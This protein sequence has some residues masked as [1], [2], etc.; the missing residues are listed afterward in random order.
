MDI[1]LP[2]PTYEVIAVKCNFINGSGNEKYNNKYAYHIYRDNDHPFFE[3]GYLFDSIDEA[4]NHYIKFHLIDSSDWR[5]EKNKERMFIYY[6]P[7]I[8][9]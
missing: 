2:T 6:K 1:K 7:L 5:I 4:F 9:I 3:S 8:K